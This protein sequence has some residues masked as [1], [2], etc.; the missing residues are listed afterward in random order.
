MDIRSY[1]K[2]KKKIID[3]TLDEYLPSARTKPAELH[4]AIKYSVFSGGKRIRPVLT[5]ACF[6]ACG[7]KGA[8]ILPVACAVELIHT[9]TLVHDDLPCMDD[10]DFRRGRLSCHKKFGEAIALLT[11]DSLLTLGFYL[12]SGTGNVK[13][14][15]EVAKAIGSRG[16]IGGQAADTLS[17]SAKRMTHKFDLD[18]IARNKT[19]ALFEVAC[20][21]GAMS[22]KA[23]KKKIRASGDFGRDLGMTFQIVDDLID[24]D[25]YVKIYGTARAEKMARFFNNK[26]KGSL[27]IFGGPGKR[28]SEISELILNRKS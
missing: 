11:G 25:G 27:K 3:K 24:K 6:E 1:I 7:G 14:V 17:Y 5:I 21:A 13:V 23:D 12:L 8:A 16:T 18:Y 9:Y 22:A 15:N 26:A 20:K 10:D 2:T 19:A 4:E 28:L